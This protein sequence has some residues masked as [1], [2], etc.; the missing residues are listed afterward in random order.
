[1]L[2]KNRDT[3]SIHTSQTSKNSSYFF[4]NPDMH[5]LAHKISLIL[6]SQEQSFNNGL[7]SKLVDGIL[8]E[9]WSPSVQYLSNEIMQINESEDIT[10]SRK[11]NKQSIM[12][13]T[14]M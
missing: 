4:S 6:M 2:Q 1:M 13:P 14:N 9:E 11:R 12:D 7:N 10:L 3:S 8:G 5:E